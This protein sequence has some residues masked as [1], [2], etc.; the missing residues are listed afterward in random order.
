M[1]MMSYLFI[2]LVTAKYPLDS[3]RPNFGPRLNL[4]ESKSGGSCEIWHKNS[5]CVYCKIVSENISCM[6]IKNNF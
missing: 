2:N 4:E 5:D 3:R 6:K 1:L